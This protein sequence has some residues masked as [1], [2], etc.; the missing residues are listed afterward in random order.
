MSSGV[1]KGTMSTAQPS[2]ER[3]L[4]PDEV[5]LSE[6]QYKVINRLMTRQSTFFT[7]AAGTGKSYIVTLL[8]QVLKKL[9]LTDRL[10]LTAPT[11]VA[12]CNISGMT[13]HSWAG[14]GIGTNSTDSY[15]KKI[16]SRGA[17]NEELR[18]RWKKTEILVIDEVS[19]LSADLFEKIAQLGSLIRKDKRPF[20]GIQVILCGDFFQL[21]PISKGGKFCFQSP[22]WSELLGPEG[23]VVLDKVFRQKDGPFVRL[24]ND[25][26]RGVV[27]PE[28]QSILTQKMYDTQAEMRAAANKENA[29][30]AKAGSQSNKIETLKHTCLFSKNAD[31]DRANEVEL[32]KLPLIN[33]TSE[34]DLLSQD[35]GRHF[36]YTA[37]ESGSVEMLKNFKAPQELE[38]R[39]GAQV[40]MLKNLDQERGLINGSRGI[41]THFVDF[42]Q[43]N[44]E[45][46]AFSKQVGMHGVRMHT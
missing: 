21:P 40:M 17:R 30:E 3:K 10:A 25:M 27:T 38:L 19:M 43:D 16:M 41:V 14:I 29:P 12:A 34:G 22:V 15:Y 35:E 23:S 8:L 5:L 28:G 2:P 31:C 33:K 44:R 45:I 39:V 6:A 26:R 9:E 4:A 11:G 42:D 37:D 20:G 7:G 32:D 46:K 36:I 1:V 18:D 24:L 13:I